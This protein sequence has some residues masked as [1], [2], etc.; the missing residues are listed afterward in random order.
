MLL[1]VCGV[2]VIIVVGAFFVCVLCGMG[3]LACFFAG[4]VLVF[5]LNGRILC[6]RHRFT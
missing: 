5:F 1:C 2:F 6:Q 4:M 3:F